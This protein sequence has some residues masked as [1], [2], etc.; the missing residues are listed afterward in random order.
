MSK[1]TKQSYVI[2]LAII[3]CSL[4]LIPIA[5]SDTQLDDVDVIIIG[6][7]STVYQFSGLHIGYLDC[8]GV[9]TENQFPIGESMDIYT[10]KGHF[11]HLYNHTAFMHD[12]EGLFFWCELTPFPIRFLPFPPFVFIR[13]HAK[14]LW[15]YERH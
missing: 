8:C 2:L 6:R 3:V 13:C 7:C 10:N 12:A 1:M 15:V 9:S 4:Y 11:K 14:H 5:R